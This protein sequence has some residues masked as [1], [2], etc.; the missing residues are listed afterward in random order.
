MLKKLL[1]LNNPISKFEFASTK[2][3][4]YARVYTGI[5]SFIWT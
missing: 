2:D 3:T 5:Y 4:I 1:L